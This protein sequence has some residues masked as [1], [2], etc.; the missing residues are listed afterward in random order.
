M[1]L[2]ILVS[3]L[4]IL[5]SICHCK[6]MES[7]WLTKEADQTQSKENAED[8]PT[9]QQPCGLKGGVCELKGE[10]GAANG[11]AIDME[12][13]KDCPKGQYCCVWLF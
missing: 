3:I 6:S 8:K 1:K 2:I 10:C 11:P 9:G 12:A 7:F 13:N 4:V 5:F